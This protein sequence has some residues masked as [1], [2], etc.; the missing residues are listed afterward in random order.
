MEEEKGKKRESIFSVLSHL[1]KETIDGPQSLENL[2]RFTVDK[3]SQF[4]KSDRVSIV[5]RSSFNPFD[6]SIP[7]SAGSNYSITIPITS[8]ENGFPV[9]SILVSKGNGSHITEKEFDLLNIFASIVSLKVQKYA[10]EKA[11][12]DGLVSI[13]KS[14]VRIVEAKDSYTR[15]HS[16]RVAEY[17]MGIAEVMGLPQEERDVL[18]TAALIHDIGKLAVPDSILL[19]PGRLSKEEFE[20]VKLHTMAGADI[21]K[22]LKS[23]RRER[24][25]VLYHHERWDGSGYPEG[26]VGNEIPLLARIVAVADSFDA[27][28]SERVYRRAMSFQQAYEELKSLA[29]IK[30]GYD[31]MEAFEILLIKNYGVKYRG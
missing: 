6:H 15:F 22:P 8:D 9:G 14:F 24:E 11:L 19:K 20:V 1:A 2:F 23:Y 18:R 31:E 28:T 21:L 5:L 17:S 16:Q 29:G 4:V 12:S 13:L 25:V 26:L 3:L 30:Y 10:L 27:M 7:A